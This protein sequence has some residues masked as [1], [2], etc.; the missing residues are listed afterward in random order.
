MS[1]PGPTPLQSFLG[2][3]GL[4]LPAQALLSL[5]SETF[6]ISG[7]IHGAARGN[8]EDAVSV[9]G[10]I[11]GGF[12]VAA[13]EGTGP[14]IGEPALLPL[15]LSG[16]LVGVGAKVCSKQPWDIKSFSDLMGLAPCA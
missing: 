1:V 14:T 3:V 10:L 13:I 11:S 6:G 5:N 7:F 8:L 2:G 15:A 12:V 16:L 4:A 9:L